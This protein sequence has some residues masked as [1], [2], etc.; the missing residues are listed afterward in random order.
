MSILN[1]MGV[2]NMKRAVVMALLIHLTSADEMT[3]KDHFYL[4]AH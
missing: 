4:M 2:V 3:V 1:L